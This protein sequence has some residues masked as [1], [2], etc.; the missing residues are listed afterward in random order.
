VG[1]IVPERGVVAAKCLASGIVEMV[2]R[3]DPRS[4]SLYGSVVV[5]GSGLRHSVGDPVGT[6]VGGRSTAGVTV[7]VGGGVV[8]D[9]GVA[10]GVA[11]GGG[12]SMVVY[13]TDLQAG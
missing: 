11:A 9:V 3:H 5:A 4:R 1:L 6:D 8:S 12:V 2:P 10:V 13:D 7:V